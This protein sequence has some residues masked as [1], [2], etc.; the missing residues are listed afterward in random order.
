MAQNCD[1]LTFMYITNTLFDV[2]RTCEVEITERVHTALKASPSG[3][4]QSAVG[5]NRRLWNR[6]LSVTQ[7]PLGARII[8]N[9]V[10]RKSW[11]VWRL[12][13][14]CEMLGYICERKSSLSYE[15][16]TVTITDYVCILHC[17]GFLGIT[18]FWSKVRIFHISLVLI[19]IYYSV[20][21][22]RR[23]QPFPWNGWSSQALST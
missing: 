4:Q 18:R 2:A 21:V 3:C 15:C 23:A 6:N 9:I 17:L 11:A 1:W 10:R 20:V 8:W 16:F 22:Q 7:K 5:G 12:I 19:I 13:T 14:V